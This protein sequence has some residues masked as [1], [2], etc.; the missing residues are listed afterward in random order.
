MQEDFEEAPLDADSTLTSFD[1]FEDFEEKKRKKKEVEK[2][3]RQPRFDLTALD[4]LEVSKVTSSDQV[5]KPQLSLESKDEILDEK[6]D[7]DISKMNKQID[8]EVDSTEKYNLEIWQQT[9]ECCLNILTL[10]NNV[11]SSINS[12]KVCQEVVYSCQGQRFIQD[13]SEVYGV[14]LRIIK[15]CSNFSQKEQIEDL[16]VFGKQIILAWNNVLAFCPNTPILQEVDEIFDDDEDQIKIC[17]ICGT[18][19]AVNRNI[20]NFGGSTYH[21]TCANLWINNIDSV[22]PSLMSSTSSTSFN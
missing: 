14:S 5:M 22:L 3:R 21:P 19:I 8:E 12:P 20:I 2:I 10:V 9:L 18:H 17:Q 4:Q 13:L 16:L 1:I 7:E 15:S 6:C 11:I